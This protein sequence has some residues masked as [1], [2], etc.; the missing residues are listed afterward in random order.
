MS[1]NL[2]SE[3]RA[4]E[5]SLERD[6][7]EVRF[8]ERPAD[9]ARVWATVASRLERGTLAAVPTPSTR[10]AG[11][12]SATRWRFG[13]IG[14]IGIASV[15]ALLF[16]VNTIRRDVQPDTPA[17][18]EYTTAPGQ[19]AVITL[20]DGTRVVLN[21]ASRMRVPMTFGVT[22][23]NVVLEGEA[24]FTVRH[25][26]KLP[27]VVSANG[28]TIRDLATTFV[29]DAYPGS[30]ATTVAVHDGRVAVH[31]ATVTS[32]NAVVLGAN[33]RAIVAPS[34][35]ISTGR[36]S[37]D[38]YTRW[39]D[40]RLVLRDISLGDAM[41]RLSRWYALEFRVA[42]PAMLSL[43]INAELPDVYDADVLNTLAATMRARVERRGHV[44]T[45]VAQ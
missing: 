3:L 16:A 30:G 4:L 44:V 45:F 1:S 39:T 12:R 2:D 42:D 22:S 20:G 34:G 21:V 19:R 17:M 37:D 27:F 13:T 8:T 18:R 7:R 9:Q 15:A 41:V 23:R 43:T 35:A 40:G 38:R 11:R 29:V 14:T 5:Q 33:E 28:T 26:P 25:D 10:Y 36:F 6:A 32:A 24:Q 31:P